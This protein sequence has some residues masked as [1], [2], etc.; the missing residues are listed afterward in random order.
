[1]AKT[2]FDEFISQLGKETVRRIEK[3]KKQYTLIPEKEV[4]PPV[5][6]TSQEQEIS[7]VKPK[8]EKKEVKR[9]DEEFIEKALD[10]A[11]IVMKTVRQSFSSEEERIKIYE[12]IRSA[13]DLFLG[14][15][16]K[17]VRINTSTR[18]YVGETVSSGTM[19]E[20]EWNNMPIVQDGQ[21]FVPPPR[22][23]NIGEYKRDLQIP[24]KEGRD[25]KA[26][27]DLN[28]IPQKDKDDLKVLMGIG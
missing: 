4:E 6:Q 21:T 7:A 26:E 10:Y 28:S 12:S 14:E 17:S 25:G 19:S 2:T 9:L 18:K 1:M 22:S 11:K 13:I 23:S 24:L 8:A 16:Q 27:V 20:E 3:E 5:E 15:E